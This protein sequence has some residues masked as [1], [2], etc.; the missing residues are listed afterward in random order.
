MAVNLVRLAIAVIW[1]LL[2]GILAAAA[3]DNP[4]SRENSLIKQTLDAIENQLQLARQPDSRSSLDDGQGALR[5]VDADGAAS[6]PQ[7]DGEVLEPAP[8]SGSGPV[9]QEPTPLTQETAAQEDGTGHE[10]EKPLPT[11]LEIHGSFQQRHY[12]DRKQETRREHTY[13]LRQDLRLE[14]SQHINDRFSYLFSADGQYDT[15]YNPEHD[16]DQERTR[17]QL[18]ECYL[19]Y[20]QGPLNLSLGKQAIRWGKSDEINPTDN[21]TPEDWSEYLNLSRAERKL[22]VWMVKADY[23]F[24]PWQLEAVWQPYFVPS[25]IPETGSDWENYLLRSYRA[26][27]FRVRRPERPSKNIRNQVV[28]AK[29]TQSTATYDVGLS[30]AYHYDALPSLHASFL[31]GEVYQLY[32]RQ[33][34]IGTDFE[35]T[36]GQWGLRGEC[37]YT[38]GDVFPTYA[39]SHT[40]A[41]VTKDAVNAIAGADYTFNNNIYLNLQY[42]VQYIPGHE[43][44]MQPR[45]FEDSLIWK[46]SR[47]FRHDTLLLEGT[48]RVYLYDLDYFWEVKCDYDLNDLLK[49]TL[50]YDMFYGEDDGTFGQ[51]NFNDQFFAK[52]KYAF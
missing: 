37:A 30:Y 51:Y 16:F 47:K 32:P 46:L 1:V 40:D 33:H 11:P 13:E 26:N 35:T 36:L 25:I 43:T 10:E 39:P 29:L 5:P 34:T 52:I 17:L 19:N 49:L 14:L 22:P 12:I 18:W 31:S 41:L 27:R 24:E 15:V 42:F 44:A 21:F 3:Q 48:G 8:D 45:Q 4:V 23:A 20:I 2:L 38:L 7:A 9:A 28:A 50:G 6:Q